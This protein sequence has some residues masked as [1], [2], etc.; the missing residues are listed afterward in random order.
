[1]LKEKTLLQ[2][3]EPHNNITKKAKV[4]ANVKESSMQESMPIVFKQLDKI[5][6]I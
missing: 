1:M 6:K 4:E 3:Q 5:L 2:E